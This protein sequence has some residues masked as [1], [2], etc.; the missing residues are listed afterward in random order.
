MNGA[1]F[2]PGIAVVMASAGIALATVRG[3]NE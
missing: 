2:R 3:L 1:L